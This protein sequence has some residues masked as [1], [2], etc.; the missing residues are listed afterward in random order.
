MDRG[1]ILS[2]V[3]AAA[4]RH[5]LDPVLVAAVAEQES[6]FDPRAHRDEPHIG[7]ASRGLMQVL[8]GTARWMGFDGEADALYDVETNLEHGCRFLRFLL[9]RYNGHTRTALAAYNAGPGN[10]D[11]RG[12]RCAAVYVEAVLERMGRLKNEMA[13]V[14]TVNG[15]DGTDDTDG[16]T[17]EDGARRAEVLPF[18]P[19]PLPV[20]F[21]SQL[22]PDG[23]GYNNCFEGATRFLTSTGVAELGA[24]VGRS[25]RVL[26]ERGWQEAEIR[27][28]GVQPLMRVTLGWA[29]HRK[30]V[31][32]TPEHRWFA[33]QWARG[34]GRVERETRALSPGD[35]L[36]P[37]YGQGVQG[38]RPSAFGIAHGIVFGDG[39]RMGGVRQPRAPASVVL[40]GAKD[41]QL[42]RYFPLSPKTFAKDVGV[43]VSDLPRYFKDPPA[44]TESRSYLYG[45]LAGYFAADGK[46]SPSGNASLASA[47]LHHAQLVREVCSILGIGTFPIQT[48]R[49]RGFGEE[50]TPLYSVTLRRAGLTDD[51]FLLAEHRRRALAQGLEVPEARERGWKVLAVEETDR[52]EEV[53]CAVVPTTRSFALEDH[54]LTGNCGPACVTMALAYNGHAAATRTVMHRVAEEIRRV[55]WHA[56]TYTNFTQ[57]REAARRFTIAHRELSDWEDVWA[58]LGSGQPILILLDN[59]LL[60][61]RQYPRSPAFN[62]HHFVILA[63]YTDDDLHVADPLSIHTHGVVTYTRASVTAAVAAVGGVQALAIDAPTAAPPAAEGREAEAQT[64][65][66]EEDMAIIR[67]SDDELKRY[68]EQLGQGVNMESAIVK[69]A[70]LAY[71]RGETRGPAVS[72]EYPARAPDGRE[73]VR[74]RFTAGIAEYDPATGEVSW[75]EVVAHPESLS[76]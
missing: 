26:T 8:L 53:F 4:R 17:G 20:P 34:H 50:K 59:A 75:V 67:I 33:Y 57:M 65:D 27:S 9:H 37:V 21:V 62:A 28:F 30:V 41:A 38:V 68:L 36:V 6:S 12:W 11:T 44:L 47:S 64:G 1:A 32:A 39:T 60:E 70:G 7:D 24:M 25:C 22:E 48:E 16:T 58:T 19:F 45:W 46:V 72:D 52:C 42:L 2:A 18:R 71:R 69:R 13:R 74:Q 31:H 40:C 23:K 51:F 10:A 61:P 73:V 49:R 3:A 43:R 15:M 66:A 5:G 63:G 14:A 56:G 35:V 76:S 55:P 29:S 54:I